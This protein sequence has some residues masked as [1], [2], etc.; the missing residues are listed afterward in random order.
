MCVGRKMCEAPQS[1]LKLNFRTRKHLF[2]TPQI[3]F[4]FQKCS[5]NSPPVGSFL[6]RVLP[7]EPRVVKTES[8][9]FCCFN[10]PQVSG[11]WFSAARYNSARARLIIPQHST[12]SVSLIRLNVPQYEFLQGPGTELWRRCQ[13][14]AEERSCLGVKLL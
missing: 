14:T 9:T 8:S 7:Q 12:S 1:L 5:F 10:F 11:K 13:G 6:S 4:L 3:C 2:K